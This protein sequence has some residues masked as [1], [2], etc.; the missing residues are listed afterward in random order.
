MPQVI[1]SFQSALFLLVFMPTTL[2]GRQGDEPHRPNVLILLADDL[3]YSDLGCYGSEIATPNLD[4]LAAGGLRYSQFYNTARCWPTRAALLTG[5]YA[6]QVNRDSL[7]SKTSRNRGERPA[8]AQ[9]LPD[10]LR[11][12]GYRSYHSGKW[13]ID[14]TPE[15]G[16]FERAYVLKDHDRFFTARNH[17]LDG[18]PLPART[19]DDNYYATTAIADYA[20]Q[21]LREH[22]EKHHEQ[23]FFQYVAFTSPHF[24]LHAP[25]EDI[26][27]YTQH[28]RIGWDEIRSTRW[29]KMRQMHRLPGDLSPLEP[30]VGPPYHSPDALLKLGPG[31]VNRELA[32]D[33][34]T[35]EQQTFQAAKMA[36]HAAMVD[37][38][39][40]EVGRIVETLKQT[41]EYENTLILFLS[42]NG[43]SA[44]IMV[45]GDGHDPQAE[46]GSAASYLCLGPGWSSAANTPMRR[47]KTWVHEGGISTPLIV[48]WP[49]QTDG[50]GQWRHSVGHVIDIA[51]TIL[52]IADGK[53]PEKAG[54][55]EVPPTPGRSLARTFNSDRAG[56][57]EVLWWFHEGNRAIRVEDWKLVSARG[58]PWELYDLG[59]DR[60][61]TRNLAESLP[62]QVTQLAK[63]WEEYTTRFEQQLAQ[64]NPTH[65][66]GTR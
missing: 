53:W 49:Q 48:H 26:A 46:A 19:L 30:E 16:G 64:G 45:R 41:G 32:W 60:A 38:M 10:L 36:V 14:G 22:H 63:L 9:L 56:E 51:P 18:N 7:P 35:D 37:R 2:I 33:T 65:Q 44:E 54:A 58:E 11:P 39:D 20:I 3:G 61:E 27:C 55:I 34:L 62:D 25:A 28:Y 12:H 13:H 8:W 42:D 40:Q 5:Y 52:E 47:H 50:A 29:N 4:A 17:V 21:F 31:E 23:P 15:R 57:R 24:S 6:Q 1:R 66:R 43:A 59:T